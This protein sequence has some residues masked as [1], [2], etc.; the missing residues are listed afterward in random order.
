MPPTREDYAVAK[1]D[2]LLKVK[3]VAE[4]CGV[5]RGTAY[6][7]ARAGLLKPMDLPGVWRFTQ[8]QVQQFLRRRPDLRDN[9]K[10]SDQAKKSIRSKS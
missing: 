7:W 5:S 4:A 10:V 1:K 6:R 9:R 3:E 8:R 2:V